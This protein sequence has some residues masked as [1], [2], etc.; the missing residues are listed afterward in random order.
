[1]LFELLAVGAQVGL[2]AGS[3]PL[4]PVAARWRHGGESSSLL[5]TRPGEPPVIPDRLSSR[6]APLAVSTESRRAGNDGASLVRSCLPS[7][8]CALRGTGG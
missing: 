4:L 6:R 8:A 3:F 1:V 2:A 5:L 7:C